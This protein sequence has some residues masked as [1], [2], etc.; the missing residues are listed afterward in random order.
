MT[1]FIL[2]GVLG[3]GWITFVH[4]SFKKKDGITRYIHIKVGQRKGYFN[5]SINGGDEKMYTTDQMCNTVHFLADNIFVKL[6]SVYFVKLLES[7]LE[8]IV[9]HFSLTC[10]FTYMKVNF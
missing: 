2:G 7:L 4:Y 8:R 3:A 1:K 5:N 9:L 10:S 6:G